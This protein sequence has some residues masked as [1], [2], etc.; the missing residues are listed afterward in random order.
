[1]LTIHLPNKTIQPKIDWLYQ[2]GET[3]PPPPF[4]KLAIF[5]TAKVDAA[6]FVVE[7]RWENWP[8]T[9]LPF[10]AKHTLSGSSY[11]GIRKQ[12]HSLKTHFKTW[13]S[14]AMLVKTEA[15]GKERW[16]RRAALLRVLKMTEAWPRWK[17]DKKVEGKGWTSISGLDRERGE[18]CD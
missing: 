10:R 17:Q 18:P 7:L 3:N 16:R 14:G 8:Q 2:R 5:T 6:C 1:M 13:I 11:A 12:I 15:R 9:Q 4:T